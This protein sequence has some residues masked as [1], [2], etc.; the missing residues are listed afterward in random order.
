MKSMELCTLVATELRV[1][2]AP[3]LDFGAA[4]NKIILMQLLKQNSKRKVIS[5]KKKKHHKIIT[6]TLTPRSREKHQGT[7]IAAAT[8]LRSADAGS[9][10]PCGTRNSNLTDKAQIKNYTF[11][12]FFLRIAQGM[13]FWI[14]K[15]T[16]NY[17]ILTWPMLKHCV[18]MKNWGGFVACSWTSPPWLGSE[19]ADAKKSFFMAFHHTSTTIC[20]VFLF[21]YMICYIH[22][23]RYI[24]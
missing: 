10:E 7:Y 18:N 4:N 19:Q 16:I 24:H 15:T 9:K 17:F 11:C 20:M 8:T 22:R 13:R 3:K 23:H 12:I 2:A 5:A 21:R 6:A 14:E 1:L